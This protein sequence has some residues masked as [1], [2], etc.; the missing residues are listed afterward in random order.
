MKGDHTDPK[1]LIRESF[2]IEGIKVNSEKKT[3]YFLLATDPLTLIF[4]F[5]EF[6]ISLKINIKKITKNTTFV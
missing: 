2:N 6:E 5:I 1:A 4:A 3:I